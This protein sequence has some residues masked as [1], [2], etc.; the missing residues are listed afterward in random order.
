MDCMEKSPRI[1]CVVLAAGQGSR[2]GENK[3][4]AEAR[5]RSLI[6]RALEAVPT[7]RFTAVV[8]VAQDPGVLS[9]AK[10]F[11]FT[12]IRNGHP[13]EGASR[14]VHLGL[15]ALETCDAIL[16][17]VADQPL[18]RQESVAALTDFWREAP[19]C[20]AAVGHGGVRGNPC[21]FPARFFPELRALTG[22]RGGSAVIRVHEDAL[23]LLEIP[24]DELTDVD[25]RAALDALNTRIDS[26]KHR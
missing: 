19:E 4:T 17:Q 9:L 21:I 10:D 18:L 26:A 5:G 7:E 1:G 11:S 12:A 23:R 2:F 22:D 16:F 15:A 25:T 6:R 13:E 3:L 8:V 24:A 20:I 14:S